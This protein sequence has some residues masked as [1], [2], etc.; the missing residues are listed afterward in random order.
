LTLQLW[1]FDESSSDEIV[2]TVKKCKSIIT[3]DS[4]V[5]GYVSSTKIHM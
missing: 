1:F 3:G 5:N 2:R 4:L